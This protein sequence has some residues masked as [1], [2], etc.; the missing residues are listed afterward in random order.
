MALPEHAKECP[1]LHATGIE[2]TVIQ[3]IARRQQLG[4]AKYGQTVA[5]NPL[6]LREW[7]LH[8]YEELLDAAVYVKRSIAEIDSKNGV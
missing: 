7:L 5:D 3:D 2:L 6:V 4:I 8:Q 1:E